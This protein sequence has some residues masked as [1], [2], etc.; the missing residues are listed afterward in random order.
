[1]RDGLAEIGKLKANKRDVSPA[2]FGGVL[3]GLIGLVILIGFQSPVFVIFNT[4]LIGVSLGLLYGRI[5]WKE[6]VIGMIMVGIIGGLFG[7]LA[8]SGG[9]G[10]LF[11]FLFTGPFILFYFLEVKLWSE[12]L[13]S[14]KLK[15]EPFVLPGGW[16]LL[17]LYTL[18]FVIYVFWFVHPKHVKIGD[19]TALGMIFG[20]FIP[21]VNIW[22]TFYTTRIIGS[23][24][25][26][27][28]SIVNL[29]SVPYF[30]VPFLVFAGY[31]ISCKISERKKPKEFAKGGLS[32]S[33]EKIRIPEI[34]NEKK[35]K[36]DLISHREKGE[37]PLNS[38]LSHL[39]ERFKTDQEIKTLKKWAE[40]LNMTTQFIKAS[41][42]VKRAQ[43]EFYR[44]DTESEMEKEK[45]KTVRLEHEYKQK[46]LQQKLQNLDLEDEY[47]RLELQKKIDE[48][49]KPS[50]PRESD[51]ERIKRQESERALRIMERIKGI[52]E[53]ME[54]LSDWKKKMR[55]EHPEEAEEIID[56]VDRMMV[57][58]GLK[59]E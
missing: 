13:K 27:S 55:R 40:Q 38:Y 56:E 43:S 34:L 57:E 11:A 12:E 46:E 16:A 36:K 18:F 30:A 14:G 4:T 44:V 5:L 42:E 45:L 53:R 25:I 37:K 6:N 54:F 15:D 2:I 48:L 58:E 50:K 52:T 59:E 33:E 8:G 9:P 26:D 28:T 10:P 41:A 51:L 1:M 23:T 39:V 20:S 31:F 3:G 24:L 35:I 17:G 19:L 47:K 7:G 21:F 32:M 22:V 49:K 29:F